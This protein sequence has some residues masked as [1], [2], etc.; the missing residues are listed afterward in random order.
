V[1]GGT[2]K[3]AVRAALLCGFALCSSSAW[4]QSLEPRSYS[5]TPVGLN[6]L[7]AGYSYAEGSVSFDPAVPLTDAHLHTNTE[8]FDYTHSLDAFGRSAK[9]DVILPVVSLAGSALFEGEPRT[10]EIAGL[11][12]PQFRVAIN[13]V[14]APALSF[15]DF[16]SYHQD[17][18]IGASLKVTAPEGQYDPT[19][20]VNIGTNRWSFKP[21]LGLSKA[22][23]SW[24]ADLYT[25]LTLYTT[26][27]DFLNGRTLQ[28][29]T[30]YSVQGHLMRSFPHGIWA[31]VDTTYYWGG[32]TT[33][34]GV[35]GNTL[36]ANSRVG[37]T[38]ALPINRQM[39]IK[40]YAGEGTSSRTHSNFNDVGVGWQYRWGGG[41]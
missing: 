18:I 21:E 7:I 15:K 14:G 17:L 9:F 6:F 4:A 19:K 16:G 26:N 34:N 35:R 24:T 13:F 30:I 2:A 22:L 28:Q 38:L 1:R 29:S 39:S 10:R 5:D 11:G 3:V 27:N 41:M 37:G 23:G 31:A 12:D 33:I 8:V 25:A 32:R 36:E 40:L 20:L